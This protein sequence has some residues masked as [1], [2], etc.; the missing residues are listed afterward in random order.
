MAS[1]TGTA[2]RKSGRG[3]QALY[4][5]LKRNNKLHPIHEDF[6]FNAVLAARRSNYLGSVGPITRPLRPADPGDFVE[7]RVIAGER[8]SACI[9]VH[10]TCPISKFQVQDDSAP[11]LFV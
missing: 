10:P 5:S 9:Q 11:S 6:K 4:R 7:V 3:T 8:D 2:K 1:D